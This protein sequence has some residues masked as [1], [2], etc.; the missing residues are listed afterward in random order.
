MGGTSRTGISGVRTVAV[1]VGDQDRAVEFYVERLGLE[2][3]VDAPLAEL[4][5]RW[6]EVAPP[7]SATTVALVPASDGAPAGV[8][9]GI[10]L[11][12]DDA[13][14][15]HRELVERG[16]AVGELLAWDGVP[17]MFTLRDP[18][19]NQLVVVG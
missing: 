10:R 9:T 17:P 12:A 11:S 4:G 5:G 3:R 7:G 1:P 18:D 19:G 15:L 6:I 13:T 2:L 14:V 16:V 8:D